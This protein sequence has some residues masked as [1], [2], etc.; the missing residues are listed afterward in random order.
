MLNFK[1]EDLQ[2]AIVERVADELLQSG[3]DFAG[4]VQKEVQARLDK[5]FSEKANAQIEAAIADSVNNSFDR[6]YHRIT[7]WGE[8]SGEKTT[9]RAELDKTINNY[10]SQ[11]VDTKN[12]KP[13]DSHYGQSITRAEYLMT[14]ICAQDFSESMK[15]AAINVTGHL[16]DGLR[17]QIAIIM[18][19]MLND[20][21]RV[22]S[23]Q[24]QGKVEKR[25]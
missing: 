25:Y 4:L 6:E 24:D 16:K 3:D 7:K 20:L 17:N 11:K 23:L 2:K 19:G 18:D 5:I 9:I 10:W 15:N 22:R 13:V 1:E 21:F 8:P 12:G 14:T